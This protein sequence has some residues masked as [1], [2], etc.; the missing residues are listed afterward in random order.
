M[1]ETYKLLL[2]L[3]TLLTLPIAVG[4][5]VLAVIQIEATQQSL[6]N[7]HQSLVFLEQQAKLTQQETK[8]EGG[9]IRNVEECVIDES[10][11]S[12]GLELPFPRPANCPFGKN[13]VPKGE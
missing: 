10:A 7:G 13:I 5:L 12:S 8:A 11:H 9:A 6:H 4:I 2:K 1:G 3:V